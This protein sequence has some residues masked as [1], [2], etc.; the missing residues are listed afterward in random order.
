[1][2]PIYS[3]KLIEDS[4]ILWYANFDAVGAW[5]FCRERGGVGERGSHL[6]IDVYSLKC[7]LS[8]GYCLYRYIFV[9]ISS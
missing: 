5:R 4:V 1:M 6:G 2:H 8:G 7:A 9:C 3:E